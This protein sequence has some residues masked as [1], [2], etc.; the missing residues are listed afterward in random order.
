MGRFIIVVLLVAAA[1]G[2]IFLVFGVPEMSREL[3]RREDRQKQQADEEN[4]KAAAQ[5]EEQRKAEEEKAAK[6][7]DQE[8]EQEKLERLFAA[9][10]EKALRMPWELALAIFHN[11]PNSLVDEMVW[12]TKIAGKETAKKKEEE[13]EEKKK[14][15]EVRRVAEAKERKRID[16]TEKIKRAKIEMDFELKQMADEGEEKIKKLKMD[17]VELEK[18][19]PDKRKVTRIAQAEW[20]QL[21]KELKEKERNLPKAIGTR[22]AELEKEIEIM[23]LE[24]RKLRQ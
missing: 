21:S 19:F 11:L 6:K 5:K 17:I 15:E 12:L 8:K 20:E 4:K 1:L 18:K 13:A 2:A 16:L 3:E 9:Q 10:K 14:V 23:E 7:K 24:E 22:K